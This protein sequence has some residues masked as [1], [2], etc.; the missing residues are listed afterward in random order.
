MLFLSGE[1]RKL[2]FKVLRIFVRAAERVAAY[3]KLRFTELA[4]LVD[5]PER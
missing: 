2:N 1:P 3:C 5:T 4:R